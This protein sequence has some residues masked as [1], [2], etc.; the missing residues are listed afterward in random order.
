[1]LSVVKPGKEAIRM[2]KMT[3]LAAVLQSLLRQYRKYA[4]WRAGRPNRRALNRWVQVCRS[5][6]LLEVPVPPE[7]QQ[8]AQL[9][10]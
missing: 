2:K 1:M 4:A 7:L 6:K 5:A 3:V 10:A 9:I 8:L